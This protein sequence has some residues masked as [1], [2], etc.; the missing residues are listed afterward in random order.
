M[1]IVNVTPD[2]F[3]DGG[4]HLE[5]RRAVDHALQLVGE[6][7]ELI[8]IGGES[9]RPGARPVDEEGEL[10]RVIPVIRAL[11]PQ[12]SVP[13]SIDTRKPAVARAALEAGASI[14]N[15]VEASR[16]DSALWKVVAEYDAGYVAMHMQGDP[17]TMQAAPAY[18]DGD[19]V[20]AVGEFF[21]DRL[22]RLAESGVS[23]Q[24]VVLDPG[25]GFGKTLDHNLSLLA[26]LKAFREFARPLLIGISRKSFL[27]ALL[28]V[29]PS[30]R[31]AA[32]LACTTWSRREGAMIFRTHDVAATV[33]SLRM[34][35]AL[36]DRSPL[37]LS[38]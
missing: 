24:Q 19:V 23:A 18:R 33:Q 16:T 28:G 15:D 32:G 12:V 17:E 31:L 10:A 3:W 20:G 35:E 22:A 8:D 37:P 6:G 29:E 1:G 34:T 30:Q 14:V 27:G 21:R 36:L 5:T 9:T 13:I 2:S 11:A 26:G 38:P 4:R 25:V 7:A